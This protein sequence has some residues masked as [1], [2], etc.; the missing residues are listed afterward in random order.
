MKKFS[1][2]KKI[3]FFFITLLAFFLSVDFSNA[4]LSGETIYRYFS[5]GEGISNPTSEAIISPIYALLKFAGYTASIIIIL[6]TAINFIIASPQQ[7]ANLKEKLWLIAIGVILLA[8]GSTLLGIVG[9][10]MEGIRDGMI[11]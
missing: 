5:E 7:K 4:A 9:K 1:L 3:R 2:L 11:G 10:T 6:V 8:G